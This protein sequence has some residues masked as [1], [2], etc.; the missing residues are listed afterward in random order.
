M[1]HAIHTTADFDMENIV[2]AD[3]G[4]V[5]KIYHS[6]TDGGVNTIVTDVTMAASG[7]RKASIR[8]TGCASEMLS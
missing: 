1:L 3:S 5:E 8:K 2:K 4:A 6:L 7:I